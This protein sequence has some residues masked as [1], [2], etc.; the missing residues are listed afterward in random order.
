MP[1]LKD[2]TSRTQKADGSYTT[3]TLD[4]DG[5]YTTGSDV[6]QLGVLL[7]KWLLSPIAESADSSGQVSDLVKHLRSKV[8]ASVAL[9]H[10]WLQD[11]P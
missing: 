4:A 11:V 10:A 8:T 6:H 1:Q 7:E 3:S 5:N 2:W 9:S